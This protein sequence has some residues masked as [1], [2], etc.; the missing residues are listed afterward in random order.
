MKL[1]NVL[2]INKLQ[3]LTCDFYEDDPKVVAKNLLGKLLVRN[4]K[5]NIL[6]GRIVETEAYYGRGDPASRA[7]KGI[8]KISELMFGESGKLL[9]YVVHAHHLVNVVAHSFNEVGAVLIRSIEPMQGIDIMKINRNLDNS[10]QL[11]SGP[12]KLTK[13]F[14]ICKDHHRLNIT[15]KDSEIIIVDD[16]I[17]RKFDIIESNRIGVKKDLPRRL[18]FYIKDNEWVSRK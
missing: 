2:D 17:F 14:G 3:P 7:Y 10:L 4:Y 13:S 6:S 12:G 5:G 18:R 1:I 8:N 9:V 11:C 16:N 15:N